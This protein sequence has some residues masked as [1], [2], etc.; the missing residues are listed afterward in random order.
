MG[1]EGYWGPLEP[2]RRSTHSRAELSA[3]PKDYIARTVKPICCGLRKDSSGLCCLTCLRHIYQSAFHGKSFKW[4]Q[5]RIQTATANTAL[6]LRGRH[7]YLHV[8]WWWSIHAGRRWASSRWRG[9]HVVRARTRPI[10]W[11]GWGPCTWGWRHWLLL[12]HLWRWG[13]HLQAHKQA[14]SIKVLSYMPMRCANCTFCWTATTPAELR[15]QRRVRLPSCAS[16]GTSHE[17][18]NSTITPTCM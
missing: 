1:A 8:S 15:T 9:A 16:N 18:T 17:C 4:P 6:L 13:P 2:C 10:P 5:K 7:R 12:L 14:H 3:K 11:W